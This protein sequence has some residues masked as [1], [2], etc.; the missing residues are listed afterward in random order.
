MLPSQRTAGGGANFGMGALSG[1]VSGLVTGGLVGGGISA[2]VLAT[3]HRGTTGPEGDPG[4]DGP[5]GITGT[6]G[7][8]GFTGP[9][10]PPGGA[11]GPTGPTGPTGQTGVPFGATGVT[12]ATGHTGP[13]GNTGPDVGPPEFIP[14]YACLTMIP[15]YLPTGD[16]ENPYSFFILGNSPMLYTH[17][18][19]NRGVTGVTGTF[20]GLVYYNALEVLPGNAGIYRVEY[21]TPANQQN[22]QSLGLLR[23]NDLWTILYPD[24]YDSILIELDEGTRLSVQVLGTDGA[25]FSPVSVEFFDVSYPEYFAF[26]CATR[27]K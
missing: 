13:T 17:L 22:N 9:T 5:T 3:S 23:D 6:T 16:G 21:Y 8:T 19:P 10:G 20:L 14:A 15:P 12:G 4:M 26:L 25:E 27:V 1:F 18:S 11:T 24:T 2:A 7:V